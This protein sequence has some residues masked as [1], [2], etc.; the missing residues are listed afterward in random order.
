MSTQNHFLIATK[1]GGVTTI[2]AVALLVTFG[3]QMAASESD[4]EVAASKESPQVPWYSG[5]SNQLSAWYF[6]ASNR[7][8]AWYCD[9]SHQMLAW[10]EKTLKPLTL[11]SAERP[12]EQAPIVYC[13]QPLDTL[14]IFQQIGQQVLNQEQALNRI[15]NALSVKEKF[16]SVALIGPPG[17]GKTLTA[18]ALRQYFPWQKNV[19][20][21][22]WTTSVPDAEQKF[23]HQFANQLSDCGMNLLI[24]DDLQ[25]HDHD[26]VPSNNKLLLERVATSNKIVLMVYIFTLKTD[27]YWAQFEELQRRLPKQMPL[28]NYRIF[29]RD[30]LKDCL[31]KELVVMQRE[32][33][34]DEQTRI[35]GK[36]LDRL[37]YAGCKVLHPLI[38]QEGSKI[39]T[40]DA[41]IC[42][43]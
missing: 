41:S 9:A 12:L 14:K 8:M 32:L 29:G 26:V 3:A 10:W 37:H 23:L 30:D 27:S 6:G 31:K 19:Q 39:D 16:R 38:L 13:S 21:Y 2:I 1:M 42:S 24:I 35:L 25:S 43:R 33:C 40:S 18:T 4:V 20:T 34:P 7:L 28:V 11:H 17:V 5:T 36:A 15:E 22:S